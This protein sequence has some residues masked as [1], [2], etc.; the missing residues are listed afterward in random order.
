M[1]PDKLLSDFPGLMIQE[2]VTMKIDV[3]NLEYGPDMDMKFTKTGEYCL[4]F[5]L[6]MLSFLK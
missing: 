5:I 6:F 3:W 4:V 1:I 2:T